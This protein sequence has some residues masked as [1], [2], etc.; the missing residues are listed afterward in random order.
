MVE[1]ARGK[2]AKRHGLPQHSHY[3]LFFHAYGRDGVM[4]MWEPRRD[5]VPHEV[6]ILIEAVAPTLDQAMDIAAL[7]QRNLFFAR[8]SGARG[9]AGVAALPFDEVLP[10]RPGYAWTVNHLLPLEDPLELF[11]IRFRI[12]FR[13]VRP[14]ARIGEGR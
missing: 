11:P 1:W 12:R 8:F 3:Q 5:G 7:A 2:V 4:G 9:T 6:G 14:G 10:A 13:E